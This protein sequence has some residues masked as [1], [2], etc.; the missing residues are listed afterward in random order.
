MAAKRE[1]QLIKLSFYGT[2]LLQGFS[3]PLLA[4]WAFSF[5]KPRENCSITWTAPGVLLPL[6]LSV[7]PGGPGAP[8]PD[9]REE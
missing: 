7:Q 9:V 1:K 5:S 8:S 6:G 4:S 3:E 2:C